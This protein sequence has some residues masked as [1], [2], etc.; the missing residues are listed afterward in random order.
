M[1]GSL[2]SVLNVRILLVIKIFMQRV[3]LE[4]RTLAVL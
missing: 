2:R 4:I 1:S 3:P